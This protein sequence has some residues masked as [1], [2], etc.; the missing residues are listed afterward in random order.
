[1][2]KLPILLLGL[3][4]TLA[5]LPILPTTYMTADRLFDTNWQ[6]PS[7]SVASANSALAQSAVVEEPKLLQLANT[8]ITNRWQYRD[9]EYLFDINIPADSVAPLQAITFSQVEGADYPS[10][11][12]RKSYVF[13]ESDRNR[14]IASATVVDD[15]DDRTV[16]V[17]F[18]PPLQSGRNITVVLKS[19]RNPRDG[20]Y[21]YQVAALPIGE[22]GR[23]RR[24]GTARLSFYQSSSQDSFYR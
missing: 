22:N 14:K 13:E 21:I 12:T 16:A 10:Y 9:A 19:F 1:M 20:I 15:F 23:S 3:G 17:I 2:K 11:S 4:T 18:D 24:L 6:S 8:S 7:T 5:I